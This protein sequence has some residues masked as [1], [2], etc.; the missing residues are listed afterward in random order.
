MKAV[1]KRIIDDSEILRQTPTLV[2]Y[3][4][5]HRGGSYSLT[6]STKTSKKMVEWQGDHCPAKII[7]LV[8]FLEQH[9]ELLLG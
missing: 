3:K 6:L 5:D 8:K 4:Q 1:F 7:P 2:Q 9:G